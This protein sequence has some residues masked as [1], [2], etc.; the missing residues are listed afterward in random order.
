MKEDRGSENI[1]FTHFQN[2]Q[3]TRKLKQTVYASRMALKNFLKIGFEGKKF[4][5]FFIAN[6]QICHFLNKKIIA[7]FFN[8]V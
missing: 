5:Y 8:G 7:G 4:L 6:N 2:L 3:G 1:F